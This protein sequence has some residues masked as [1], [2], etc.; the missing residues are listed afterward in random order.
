MKNTLV[1]I[2]IS[3]LLTI[4]AFQRLEAQTVA[5]IPIEEL[6]SP[7]IFVSPVAR[8]LNN[9]INLRIQFGQEIR[10]ADMRDSGLLGPDGKPVPFYSI[11][12][13]LNYLYDYGYDYEDSIVDPTGGSVTYILKKK[14]E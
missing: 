7:Y 9:R 13:G 14:E 11:V 6:N 12:Q 10:M 3:S 5:G 1:T 2:I 8:L 4:G